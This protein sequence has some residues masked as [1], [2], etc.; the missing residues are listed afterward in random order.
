MAVGRKC[1]PSLTQVNNIQ[2]RA[3]GSDLWIALPSLGSATGA[4]YSQSEIKKKK[5]EHAENNVKLRL[6]EK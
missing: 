3:K 1:Q 2:A 5:N 6:T 4:A